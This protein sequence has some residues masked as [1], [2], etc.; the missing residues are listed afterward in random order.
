MGRLFGTDGIRGVA[1]TYPLTVEMFVKIGRALVHLYQRPKHVPRIIIGK[2]TRLSG[3]ML[4]SALAAGI[5]SAGANAL[6]AGV[7]PTPGIAY[8]TGSME[9]DAGVV[10]SAS[11]NPYEDNGIKIFDH[12][13]FKLTDDQELALE[14]FLLDEAELPA[15]ETHTACG[16]V[17]PL[18]D[19]GLRYIDFLKHSF[20]P[21]TN[22]QGLSVILDCSQGATFQVAPDL[23]RQLDAD[24]S[25]LFN[26]PDGV[27]INR[28]CGSQHPETLA[29]TVLEQ[30]AAAGFAF[31]GDGD[32]L[33][34]VD[35]KG[36]ILTG[37]QILTICAAHLKK[38][39]RL[40]NNLVVRT[41]MSN[42]GMSVALQSLGIDSILTDVGDRAVLQ[43]ML[44]RNAVIGGEDSGHLIFL[45]HHKTGDGILSALQLL[46]VMKKEQ[47]PLSELATVMTIFPQF[48]INVA[49]AKKVD[50]AE[51]PE[52]AGIIKSVEDKL[53]ND[54]RVLVRY[55]GTQNICRVMVEGPTTDLTESYCR[56][57]AT[58]VQNKLS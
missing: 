27:N 56:E 19:A 17:I 4:E 11:H 57:I 15:L 48:L 28:N 39:N 51:I 1:N 45:N 6:V 50:T 18:A 29:R 38:E 7:L 42:C 58:V 36:T 16:R 9:A 40:A 8:L 21:E 53:G 32:R 25:V 43:T 2:D 49:V 26:Q 22:L 14:R 37:D 24:V 23:F 33:I 47:R 30:G 44:A 13:G 35:E 31:D 52:I 12:S 20:L 3:D 54:G 55:S 5:C 46:A 10:I 41:V 34:A